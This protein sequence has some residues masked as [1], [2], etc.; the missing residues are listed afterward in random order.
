MLEGE[1]VI[2]AKGNKPVVKITML[3]DLKPKRKLGSAKD[4]IKMM[5]IK[6]K[7]IVALENLPYYHQDPFDRLIITQSLLEKIPV[8]SR[9]RIFDQYPIKKIW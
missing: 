2:I 1:D 6:L 7:H 4:K 3:D 5:D 9:D 8:L